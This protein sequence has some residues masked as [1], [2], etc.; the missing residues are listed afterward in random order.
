MAITPQTIL[1]DVQSGAV[2]ILTSVAKVD[3]V[4]VLA[5]NT[6]TDVTT[7]QVNTV[8][9]QVFSGARPIKATVKE[10]A[11]VMDYPVETGATYSDYRISNPTEIELPCLI[12]Q[13]DYGT[14]Y[15]AIRN[16]WRNATLLSVQT[17]TGTYQN[18]I[19]ADLPHEE[20]AEMFTSISILLKLREVILIAPASIAA[21]PMLANYAPASPQNSMTVNAGLLA[22]I[23]A[24]TSVLSY[25]HASSVWR[26]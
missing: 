10:T 8:F 23:A 22:G 9:A 25:F 3:V 4:A 2:D 17:R 24:P 15:Q 12:A 14:A 21:Q 19:I 11:K 6:T 16:A 13:A 18:M 26:L 7:G 20:D 1:S 5:Q